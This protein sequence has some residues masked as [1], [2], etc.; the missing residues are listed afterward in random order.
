MKY[1]MREAIAFLYDTD[2]TKAQKVSLCPEI[3]HAC[4]R[5][6]KLR[7]VSIEDISKRE[8]MRYGTAEMRPIGNG[9][10]GFIGYLGKCSCCGQIF[11]HERED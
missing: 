5:L 9:L 2:P 7:I 1:S 6:I 11:Y 3:Y 4:P 8:P 10:D